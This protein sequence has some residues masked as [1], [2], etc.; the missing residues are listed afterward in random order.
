MLLSLRREVQ[1][2]EEELVRL[3]DALENAQARR[4]DALAKRLTQRVEELQEWI[5]AKNAFITVHAE[6]QGQKLLQPNEPI[7]AITV[8]GLNTLIIHHVTAH[9]AHLVPQYEKAVLFRGHLTEI[10][11]Q[12]VGYVVHERRTTSQD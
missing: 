10:Q 2:L 4:D 5:V 3:A 11:L 7:T 12:P 8:D 1:D 9:T 6:Y